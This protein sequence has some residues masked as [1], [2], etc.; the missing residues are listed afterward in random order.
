[1]LLEF[2]AKVKIHL[3][4]KYCLADAGAA[5]FTT[6]SVAQAILLR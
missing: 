1:M 3:P 6:A 2:T 5:S 4:I